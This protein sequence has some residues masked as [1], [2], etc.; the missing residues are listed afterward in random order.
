MDHLTCES[1][2]T[3]RLKPLEM[4]PEVIAAII[5]CREVLDM[6]GRICG[7]RIV[8]RKSKEV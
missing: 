8:W 1:G 4:E 5:P 3:F 6:D 7:A 2:H